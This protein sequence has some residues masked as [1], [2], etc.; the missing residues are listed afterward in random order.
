MQGPMC[1]RRS[2]LYPVCDQRPSDD[3]FLFAL[4]PSTGVPA[5]LLPAK[6]SL[7]SNSAL[8]AKAHLYPKLK[9]IIENAALP[10]ALGLNEQLRNV[11][12]QLDTDLP[13]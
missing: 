1:E 9:T 5:Y 13:H 8:L 7:Y 2:R 4:L 11:G 12:R 10:S 6:V 3:V